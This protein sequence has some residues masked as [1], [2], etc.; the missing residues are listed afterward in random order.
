MFEFDVHEDG[1]GRY[2]PPILQLFSDGT[3]SL[4]TSDDTDGID[5]ATGVEVN[6]ANGDEYVTEL[7]FSP[8]SLQLAVP[9]PASAPLLGFGPLALGWRGRRAA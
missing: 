2:H 6:A 7:T 9:E 8:G 4:R 3:G 1:T 5:L